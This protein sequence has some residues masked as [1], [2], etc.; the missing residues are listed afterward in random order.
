MAIIE[1]TRPYETL[2]R[3]KE[4]GSIGAHHSQIN[5]IVKDGVVISASLQPPVSIP[6]AAAGNPELVALLGQATADALANAEQ[7][8]QLLTQA[9]AEIADL[10]AKAAA[11]AGML[12]EAE[13][14]LQSKTADAEKAQADLTAALLKQSDLQDSVQTKSLLITQLTSQ[15][16]QLKADLAAAQAAIPAPAAPQEQPAPEAPAV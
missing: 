13:S 1:R 12:A 4:D 5:E 16:E 9:Q 8:Q 11:S 7:K 14:K 2:I 3:H 6:E 10:Q 15:V